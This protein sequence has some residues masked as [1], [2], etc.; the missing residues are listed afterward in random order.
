MKKGDSKYK[1]LTVGYDV[2]E[3]R[4]FGQWIM[5]HKGL[6]IVGL[7]TIIVCIFVIFLIFGYWRGGMINDSGDGVGSDLGGDSESGVYGVSEGGEYSQCDRRKARGG[8]SYTNCMVSLAVSIGEEVCA[9]DSIEWVE[10]S[11]SGDLVGASAVDYC[12]SL[13]ADKK[14]DISY[15]GN[16]VHS[17]MKESCE[18]SFGGGA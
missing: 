11:L 5:S 1:K 3:H 9:D 14:E 7:G 17:L 10:M 15:C 8:A 16:I 18:N 4:S 13:M 12:W 6:A 2:L